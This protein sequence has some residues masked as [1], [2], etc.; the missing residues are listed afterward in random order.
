MEVLVVEDNDAI[1]E[2]ITEILREEGFEACR[3][4]NGRAALD[5]LRAGGKAC[6]ILLDMTMPV[7]NGWEFREEQWKD[8]AIS[9]IPVIICTADGH[10]EKKAETLKAA[11]WMRKPVDPVQLV[12]L[13]RIHCARAKSRTDD[14]CRTGL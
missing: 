8:P 10:A 9:E 5:M 7:M 1:G 3:A 2:A 11:A 12:E 13:V 4:E 6:V 14:G